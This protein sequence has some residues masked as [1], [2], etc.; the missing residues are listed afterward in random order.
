MKKILILAIASAFVA[1]AVMAEVTVY[2]SLRT[3]LEISRNDDS[4]GQSVSRFRLADGDSRIGFKGTDKLDSG[5]TLLW[6]S[7]ERVRA[8]SANPNGTTSIDQQGWSGRDTFVGLE[9]NFGT[10]RFGT[11]YG[12][13]I[14]N[15]LGDFASAAGDTVDAAGG[16][17][18]SI[19]RG[20]SSPTN[21]VMYA[22]PS[23]GGFSF[24][25]NYDFGRKSSTA[26]A[27]SYAASAFYNSA[28]FDIGAAYK[29]SKDTNQPS[30][31]TSVT[32]TASFTPV[33]GDS[34]STYLIAGQIKP[35]NGLAIATG[36]QRVNTT[37][38]TGAFGDAHQDGYG[39]AATYTLAKMAYQLAAGKVDNV[40]GDN[41]TVS[42][43]G[44]TTYNGSMTYALS[45]QSQL[46]FSLTYINNQ[47]NAGT[48]TNQGFGT[49]GTAT[50]IAPV[51]AGGK[52]TVAS[53]GLRTDF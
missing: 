42:S 31:N 43:T 10:V 30:I 19:R 51:S 38:T 35:I 14:D 5:L 8:G 44:Y 26:N 12:D 13:T 3:G 25:A 46:R 29:R 37:T 7:E 53:V 34:F 11:A 4:V 21:I 16:L 24:K 36:W 23:F 27:Y 32:S 40:K 50:G 41:V 20:N 18:S 52:A 6:Q 47:N 2:G 45:K 17:D 22:S 49:W 48:Y 33:S 28:L 9:G 15:A 39:L 1:P